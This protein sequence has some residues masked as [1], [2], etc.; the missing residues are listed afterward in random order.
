MK[1]QKINKQKNTKKTNA[2]REGQHYTLQHQFKNVKVNVKNDYKK[3]DES[4]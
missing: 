4:I 3:I 1:I 2:R